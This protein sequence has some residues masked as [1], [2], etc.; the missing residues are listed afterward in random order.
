M[1]RRRDERDAS[2]GG[3]FRTRAP[4]RGFVDESLRTGARPSGRVDSPWTTRQGALPTACPHSR[5]SRP[6]LHRFDNEFFLL[7]QENNTIQNGD[8]SPWTAPASDLCDT[9]GTAK[10]H[11]Q[12]TSPIRAQAHHHTPA[13]QAHVL[14][15]KR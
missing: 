5:A 8:A 4:S 14:I 13:V 7:F 15:G 2:L 10:M 12:T 3:V 11:S 1:T 9:P 6:Q